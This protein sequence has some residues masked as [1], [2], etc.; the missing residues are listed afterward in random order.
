MTTENTEAASAAPPPTPDPTDAPVL[1]PGATPP[2][3]IGYAVVRAQL[4]ERAQLVGFLRLM[5]AAM[6]EQC[7]AAFAE[8]FAERAEK[9]GEIM[10][11]ILGEF[12]ENYDQGKHVTP[13]ALA[14][15]AFL[16][17]PAPDL[18]EQVRTIAIP[19]E[20]AEQGFPGYGK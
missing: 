20:L 16:D 18:K 3:E 19:R 17:V 14:N 15:M 10:G 7:K 5:E 13:R 4:A 8:E 11:K 2:N 9:F 1:D 6:P 12:A